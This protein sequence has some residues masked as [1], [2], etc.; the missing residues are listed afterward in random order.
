MFTKNN[1]QRS[2]KHTYVLILSYS[3]F[4]PQSL[5]FNFS[6]SSIP[7]HWSVKS[8]WYCVRMCFCPLPHWRKCTIVTRWQNP[9]DGTELGS[10]GTLCM[11]SVLSILIGEWI[12]TSR[13]NWTTAMARVTECKFNL[14]KCF[15]IFGLIQCQGCR[16]IFSQKET[17]DGD[18]LQSAIECP[19]FI[20][21][22][23]TVQQLSTSV[24]TFI[25]SAS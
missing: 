10:L 9:I 21:C 6:E 3:F 16:N 20:R 7:Q 1:C 13:S 2:C 17:L 18:S 15:V 19:A 25:A 11:N 24:T 5:P 12:Y 4:Q 8:L 14:T 22:P 23:P